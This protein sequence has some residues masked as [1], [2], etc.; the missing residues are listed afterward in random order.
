MPHPTEIPGVRAAV[1]AVDVDALPEDKREAF[2]AAQ[3]HAS[4]VPM[5]GAVMDILGPLAAELDESAANALAG[6]AHL[7]LVNSWLGRSEEADTLRDAARARLTA[8]A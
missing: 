6:A 2:I 4:P 7:V 1:A 8:L 3:G 5:C